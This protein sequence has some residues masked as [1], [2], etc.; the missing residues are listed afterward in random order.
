MERKLRDFHYFIGV[1]VFAN[2]TVFGIL[3]GSTLVSSMP[4]GSQGAAL[5]T[6]RK[7]S[8]TAWE[9]SGY[10]MLFLLLC[11]TTIV[12]YQAR[13]WAIATFFFVI[14]YFGIGAVAILLETVC[15]GAKGYVR[16]SFNAMPL[17]A[18]TGFMALAA[19]V[20]RVLYPARRIGA[21]L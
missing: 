11:L 1:A 19:L 15:V 21:E 2:L 14:S 8:A 17:L 6:V 20:L 18:I 10:S 9:W 7:Y 16:V 4:V 12:I 3:T 5:N 13:D